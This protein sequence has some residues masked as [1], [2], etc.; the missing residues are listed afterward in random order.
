MVIGGGGQHAHSFLTDPIVQHLT[1]SG[2]G[3]ETLVL[4]TTRTGDWF[5]ARGFESR[6]T[7]YLTR[8][9]LP[10]HRLREVDP[11]RESMLFVKELEQGVVGPPGSRI[12]Y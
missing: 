8:G 12:G 1:F 2:L 4:L 9:I 10:E 7:A 11:R 5:S 3:L 6:G